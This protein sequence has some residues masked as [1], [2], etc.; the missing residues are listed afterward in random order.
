MPKWESQVLL[1][2]ICFQL[3]GDFLFAW[4]DLGS[5]E[6]LYMQ[7]ISLELLAVNCICEV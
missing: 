5:T 2:T 4:V 3:E 6:T 1:L 7:A